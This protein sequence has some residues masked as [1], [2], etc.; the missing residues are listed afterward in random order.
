MIAKFWLRIDRWLSGN[1]F[2]RFI[3]PFVLAI[4][5]FLAVLLILKVSICCGTF[6]LE[7]LRFAAD[8]DRPIGDIGDAALIYLFTNGGQNSFPGHPLIGNIIT[9]LGILILA[10][11]TS[12]MT[13]YFEKRA[14]GY[15][16]GSTAYRLENH[17]VI[18]GSNDVIY[19][20]IN[21]YC[22]KCKYLNGYILVQTNRDVRQTRNEVFSFLDKR[23]NRDNIIFIYGDRTSPEDLSKLNLP[24]A[25]ELFII[26]DGDEGK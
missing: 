25:N 13:N 16:S 12:A 1:G 23:I 7:K 22:R 5:A 20:I 2:H 10:I 17:L 8:S 11:V 26:G 19:S 24:S 21:Q 14:D 6:E 4:G 9:L 3:I 18:L 15:L